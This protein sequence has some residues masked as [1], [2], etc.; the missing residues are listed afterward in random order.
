MDNYK[1][2]HNSISNQ[3]INYLHYLCN[4]YYNTPKNPVNEIL[5]Y[6][7]LIQLPTT[8]ITNY[9]R[10]SSFSTIH[11]LHF[12]YR[13]YRY[14]YASEVYRPQHRYGRG[15]FDSLLH[16]IDFC[17]ISGTIICYFVCYYSI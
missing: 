6:L 9:H 1:T 10:S 4:I 12:I 14:V 7:L 5:K 17:Q 16:I 11:R 8:T 2:K 15:V 3:K 13:F